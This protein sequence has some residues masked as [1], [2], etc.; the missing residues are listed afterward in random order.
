VL[1]YW[2]ERDRRIR[3]ERGYEGLLLFGGWDCMCMDYGLRWGMKRERELERERR[4]GTRLCF[5]SVGRK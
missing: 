3:V 4:R 2:E 1:G 5:V